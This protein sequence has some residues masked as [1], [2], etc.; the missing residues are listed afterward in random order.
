MLII[1][2]STS[3]VS[4]VLNTEL[5]VDSTFCKDASPS[6]IWSVYHMEWPGVAVWPGLDSFVID[7]ERKGKHK[8]NGDFFKRS[9]LED[10]KYDVFD[11]E[12]A[13]ATTTK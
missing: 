13:D 5:S 12:K 2:I 4:I 10:C 8:D 3:N 11:Q 7:K 9:Q 1:F 6:Y